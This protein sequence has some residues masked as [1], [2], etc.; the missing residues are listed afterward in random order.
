ME[1]KTVDQE[2]GADEGVHAG[3]PDSTDSGCKAADAYLMDVLHLGRILGGRIR[4]KLQILN[5]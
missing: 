5:K 1:S 4:R 2:A 3:K